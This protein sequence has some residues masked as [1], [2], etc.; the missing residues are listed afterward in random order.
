MTA[1]V[2]G[3]A[4]H[5][6]IAYLALFVAMTGT[7]VAATQLPRNSV[8]TKQIKK[9]AVTGKKVKQNT[10]GGT[11]IKESKL[12]QVPLAAKALAADTATNATSA[13]SAATAKKADDATTVGGQAPSAFLAA[14]AKATDAD[15]L[16]GVDSTVFG[17]TVIVAGVNFEPRASAAVE[18]KYEGTGAISCTGT[19][20]DF[21]Y[22]VQLPQGARVTSLDYRVVDN[23]GGSNSGLELNAFNSMGLSG[24]VAKP[25]VSAPSS[26]DDTDQHTVTKSPDAPFVV[27]NAHD[28]L[29]LIWSP[30]SCSSNTQLVGAAIHYDLPR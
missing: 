1:R 12:A 22:R 10:L 4:R 11:Q 27:N 3:H 26:F 24:P 21:Q 28:S 19:H 30:A 9:A 16:D 15:K 29:Q 18:K 2:L 14:G 7:A 6:L 20:G 23:D 17:D 25:V 13:A 8:G 5:N